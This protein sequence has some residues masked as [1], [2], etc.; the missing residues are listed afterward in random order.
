MS[1]FA[2]FAAS[3]RRVPA[4]AG[5]GR[6]WCRESEDVMSETVARCPRCGRQLPPDA[7][8]GLCASCLLTAGAETLTGSSD[9][10]ST[11]GVSVGDPPESGAPR[12]V[13]GQLWGPY[14]IVR[15]LGRGGMGEVYE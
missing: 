6:I 10:T 12:L 7:P 14:R 5:H 9:A 3:A 1:A 15:L 8:E 13:D 11:A 2:A 4:S